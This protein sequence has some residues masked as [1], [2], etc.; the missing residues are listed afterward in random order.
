MGNVPT[1]LTLQVS[2]NTRSKIQD[3]SHRKYILYTYFSSSLEMKTIKS[4]PSG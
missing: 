1:I 3:T 4:C 2:S